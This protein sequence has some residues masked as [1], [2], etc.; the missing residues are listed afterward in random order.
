MLDDF[1]RQTD[2]LHF[3]TI[4]LQDSPMTPSILWRSLRT[5]LATAFFVVMVAM[6][7]VGALMANQ[8]QRLQDQIEV[9]RATTEF[10]DLIREVR[11]REFRLFLYRKQSELGELL[12]AI[13][14]T[15]SFLGRQAG[16]LVHAS[17]GQALDAIRKDLD[18]YK[19]LVQRY[20]DKDRHSGRAEGDAEEGIRE[21][22]R[23]FVAR[24]ETV[25]RAARR[26]VERHLEQQRQ[27]FGAGILGLAVLMVAVAQFLI[28]RL[29]RPLRS[30]ESEM[31]KVADGRV[32][33]VEFRW[34]DQE[35]VSLANA[36][37]HVM[38][39]L[40]RRQAGAV[41]SE[42]L[43][44][45]GTML[46]GVAHELNNPLSN[47]S[48][49]AQILLE[50]L[51]HASREQLHTLLTRIDQQSERAKTIVRTLLDHARA[52]RPPTL[53]CDLADLVHGAI[54]TFNQGRAVPRPILVDVE[55]EVELDG[56]P[57][58]L[59]R[60][61]INLIENA[62]QATDDADPI[63]VMAHR[64]DGSVENGDVEITIQDCGTGMPEAV[65]RHAFDPFF[66]TKPAGQGTGLG[67]FI[68]HEI[69]RQ[70]RGRI[71]VVSLP[72]TG[73]SVTMRL[74]ARHQ[75]SQK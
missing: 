44:S 65:T 68:V 21:L 37:N 32:Q 25:A 22:R 50:D 18:E 26:D 67:L 11:Y 63:V 62:V 24:T 57:D 48:T 61:M 58:R 51:D 33:R 39:E 9:E 1:T 16:A 64:A 70:H 8:T 13:A 23:Q 27:I 14:N 30:I 38:S 2:P 73:T 31:E 35:L 53:R 12:A 55:P 17:G 46:S 19:S 54:E 10:F 7:G 3:A 47:I 41:Q 15:N 49:S 4:V 45:L 5:K 72:G 28:G 59:Q 71:D 74:P 56:V 40:E 66:T 52:D 20:W 60:A 42:K 69:V 43:A 29:L 75:E 6:V 34:Q 36:F